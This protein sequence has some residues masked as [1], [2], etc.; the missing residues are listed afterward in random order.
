[1]YLILI[2]FLAF[3]LRLLGI[4]H[5]YPYSFYPDEAHFVK[6]A[7]SFGTG[8]LNPHWF[9]KPAFFMYL[10]F[11]EY[12][13]FFV[14]GKITSM[15]SSA[16]DFA[17]AFIANPGPFYV[18]GR[19][20][21]AVFSAGSIFITYLLCKRH[22][23]VRIG[24][25]AAL[26]LALCY[27]DISA[28]QDIKADIPASFF[29]IL[30]AYFLLNY[31]EAHSTKQLVFAIMAAGAGTATKLYPYV[32]L[33]PVYLSIFYVYAY[34]FENIKTNWKKVI[35]VGF[36]AIT[37]FYATFFVC[38]PYNFLDPLGLKSTF[39]KLFTLMNSINEFFSGASTKAEHDF[40]NSPLSRSSAFISYI[41]TLIR[42][43][44]MGLVVGIISIAGFIYLLFARLFKI[45]ILLLFPLLFTFVS[46]F[47]FPGYAEPRHQ[48][49]VYAFLA[50]GG[51][52]LIDRIYKKFNNKWLVF[53][54][55]LMLLHPLALV[56]ERGLYV[57]KTDTRNIAKHWI[58][59]NI[60]TESKIVLDEYGPVL[61]MS[62]QQLTQAIKIAEK[63]DKQGQFTAHYAKY[64][65]FQMLAARKADA[66]Y[67][68]SEIRFPWWREKEP[69]DGNYNLTDLDKDMGNPLR[70]PGVK[71]IDIYKREGYEYVVVS[72]IR[73]QTFLNSNN[74]RYYNF[75]SFRMF[76]Q[77]LFE[78]AKLVKEFSPIETNRPGPTIKIYQ[79]S[80]HGLIQDKTSAHSYS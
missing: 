76:Y 9:H 16:E 23:N 72:S 66:T 70:P 34:P 28:S 41:Q 46:I 43:E 26:L 80:D 52:Y 24:L 27:G 11:V 19:I 38:S 78:N 55:L 74:N 21:V 17:V 54:L 18:I 42:M 12:G 69:E 50:I 49:P 14:I 68:I 2:L 7:L 65:N 67:T 60:P 79:I 15:W 47:V 58:E 75:S 62:E 35:G 1:M 73:Y 22:F 29:T 10:L 51:G 5:D 37:I 64:L 4:W 40:I 25:F 59:K 45:Y 13:I 36:A 8:D 61:H 44:G 63:A 6:R 33:V 71:T 32:M 3:L 56:L 53:A 31:L 57:S 48:L 20:L 77:D 30:S 39:G